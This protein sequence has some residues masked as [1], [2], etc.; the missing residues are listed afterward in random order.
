MTTLI[1]PQLNINGSSAND[2]IAPRMKAV[3]AI[4]DVIKFLQ[5]AT[6][7]GRDYPG[8]NI[9]CVADRELHYDRISKLRDLQAVLLDEALRIKDQ[10]D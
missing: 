1:T 9:A 8:N 10:E 2:L 5:Q 3:T 4:D 6:P 7:N